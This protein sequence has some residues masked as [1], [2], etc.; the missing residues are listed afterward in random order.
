MPYIK[1]NAFVSAPP[2]RLYLDLTW[3]CAL[4]GNHHD[5][6]DFYRNLIVMY[7]DDDDVVAQSDF[8]IHNFLS[9]C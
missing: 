3:E 5:E 2:E 4:N 6:N 1:Y 8:H 7:V 9:F